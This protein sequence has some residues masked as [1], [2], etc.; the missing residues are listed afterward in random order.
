MTISSFDTYVS[1]QT[2]HAP[3]T[4][5]LWLKPC[6]IQTLGDNFAE[7]SQ[8]DN[9]AV[10]STF[11]LPTPG[12]PD[13]LEEKSPKMKPNFF[14]EIN[15]YLTLTAEKVVQTSGLLL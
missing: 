5:L 2:I 12:W 10:F 8:F 14:V 11:D 6:R 4:A 9:L 7:N 1:T 13:E 3:T 15:T